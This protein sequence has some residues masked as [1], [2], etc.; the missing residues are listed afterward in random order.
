MAGVHS[1]LDIVVFFFLHQV[2]Y[3]RTGVCVIQVEPEGAGGVCGHSFD[4]DVVRCTIP[5]TDFMMEIVGEIHRE[6]VPP[7]V[8][9]VS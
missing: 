4:N 9:V 1:F 7:G 5:F 6:S 3:L 2:E 8:A